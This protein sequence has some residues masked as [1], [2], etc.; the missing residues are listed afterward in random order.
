MSANRP[1]VAAWGCDTTMETVSDQVQADGISVLS[2]VIL[3]VYQG[4]FSHPWSGKASN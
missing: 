3:N 1:S 4:C 2:I